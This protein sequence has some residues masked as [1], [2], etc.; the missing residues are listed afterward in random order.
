MVENLKRQKVAISLILHFDV[1]GTS[2]QCFYILHDRRGLSVHFMLDVDGTIYQTLDLKERAWQ[3]TKSNDRSIG[4]EIANIG[5]YS[6]GP[7]N[8]TLQQWYRQDENGQTY[9][10]FPESVRGQANFKNQVLRP[11]KN[12]PIVG[13]IRGKDYQQYDFT[14]QQ[15]E[16]LIRLSMQLSRHL[17]EVETGHQ[18]L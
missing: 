17:S 15:Y 2:G 6:A 10:V 8:Q 5:G 9:L 11:R 4:I 14:S 3:A 1:C 7:K 13:S 12:E 16:S 18:G